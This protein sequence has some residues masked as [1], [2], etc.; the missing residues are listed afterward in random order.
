MLNFDPDGVEKLPKGLFISLHKTVLGEDRD[1]IG[2]CEKKDVVTGLHALIELR[3]I[4]L[5][6]SSYGGLLLQQIRKRGGCVWRDSILRKL[7]L[8]SSCNFDAGDCQKQDKRFKAQPKHD[9]YNRVAIDDGPIMRFRIVPKRRA[10]F[11]C[12]AS[13][14]ILPRAHC[15]RGHPI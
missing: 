4:K 10:H 13:D 7:L 11:R 8:T 15:G 3:E 6:F 9:S 12:E 1:Y 2:F 14:C 5:S